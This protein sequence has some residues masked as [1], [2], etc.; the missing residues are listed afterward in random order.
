M[1]EHW[2]DLLQEKPGYQELISSS[3]GVLINQDNN[4]NLHACNGSH[5]RLP[6]ESSFRKEF[7]FEASAKKTLGPRD[8][9]LL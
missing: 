6:R 8:S 3:P 5:R 2:E 4:L 9:L 7:L 1:G